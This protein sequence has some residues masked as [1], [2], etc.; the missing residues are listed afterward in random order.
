MALP[1]LPDLIFTAAGMAV[2]FC[3][4]TLA[5]EYFY[6]NTAA[7]KTPD[8]WQRSMKKVAPLTAQKFPAAKQRRLDKLLDKN[9]EGTITAKEKGALEQLVAQVEQWTVANVRRLADFSWRR[10]ESVCNVVWCE[11]PLGHMA[12]RQDNDLRAANRKHRAMCRP[13]S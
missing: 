5:Q 10:P 9:S 13:A 1:Y 6:D 12:N 4:L 11:I 2:P 7:E 8:K 3:K